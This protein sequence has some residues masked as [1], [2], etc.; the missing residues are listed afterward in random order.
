MDVFSP[1]M[2]VFPPLMQGGAPFMDV[3]PPL[4]D[5]CPLLIDV[6]IMFMEVQMYSATPRRSPHGSILQG[7]DRLA[8]SSYI[9]IYS[10]IYDSG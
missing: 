7:L 2:D 1:F 9:R 5:V 4:M 8:L 3:C 10:V 6:S